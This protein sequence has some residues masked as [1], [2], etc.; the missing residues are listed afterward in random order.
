MTRKVFS[1][2]APFLFAVMILFFAVSCGPGKESPGSEDVSTEI[3]SENTVILV[4]VSLSNTELI[5]GVNVFHDISASGGERL[6]WRSTDDA[7]ASVSQEGR[8]T[9]NSLGE[10]DIM[11]ENEFGNTAA[12]HVT[13]RKSAF[14]T[15]DD[16]PLNHCCFILDALKETDAKATFFVV[17][18]YN[19]AML[20]RIHREGHF[21]GMH[22]YSHSMGVC[23]RS[24]ASYLMDLEKMKDFL[25]EQVGVRPDVIRFPG[26]ASNTV[27]YNNPLFMERLVAGSGDL[28]YRVFDWTASGGDAT[29]ESITSDDVARRAN[30]QCYRDMD[31]ILLHDKATTADALRKLV[32]KLRRR[33]Y[34]L[35]TLD[36]CSLDSWVLPTS[37]QQHNGS[38]KKPCETVFLDVGQLDMKPAKTV[39][40]TATTDPTDTTDFVRFVSDDPLVASVTLDGKVTSN[41][42]GTTRI[43]AIASSGKEAVC[44]VTV[45]AY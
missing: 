12:C 15:I 40:L 9:G 8:I 18:T 3:T 44:Y 22:T 4:S 30:R 13:V 21:I 19:T 11:V 42:I 36:H 32:P 24:Q 5:T 7:I 10:C 6:T 27:I 28:G 41:R 16:G 33:G 34:I 43:R 39:Q 23:Y 25:E 14:I 26:G 17:K 31:I 20:K 45:K 38:K 37:Y 29:T 35:E 2:T 1:V